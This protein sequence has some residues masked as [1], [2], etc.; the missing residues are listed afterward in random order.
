MPPS[1]RYIWLDIAKILAC[2]LV[3]VNHSHGLSKH[4]GVTTTVAIFDAVSF[5]ICKIAVPI[6]L[7]STGVLL[8]QKETTWKKT[9]IR[10]LRVAVPLLALSIYYY[11]KIY[12]KSG[13]ILNFC[14]VFI[15]AP[16]SPF[17][18]YLYMLVGLYLGMPFVHKIIKAASDKELLIFILLFLIAPAVASFL[19]KVLHISISAQFW[20]AFFPAV[21][22]YLI[23]GYVLT[24]ISLKRKYLFL[25]VS[26]LIASV[27]VFAFFI[28]YTYFQTGKITYPFDDLKSLPISVASL[29]AFYILR[30]VFEN[31]QFKDKTEK[32][33]T[34]VGGTTFGI[35]LIH[36][37]TISKVYYT[38]IM[39]SVFSFDPCIGTI[40]TQ[41]ICFVL[42]AM[43]IWILK[44]IP[45]IKWFL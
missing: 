18:W 19:S 20:S 17:L 40:M 16:L 12:G 6:F 25:S 43:V 28:L 1:K 33:I 36:F 3:I 44:K 38:G 11:V 26:L 34:T 2:F 13:S 4:A 8:L 31:K 15:E 10:I 24:R 37:M 39:Q 35:Y 21:L 29:S 22:V 14:R 27:C 41:V 45:G 23:A 9:I 32:A 5:A 30:Y 42:C 7:M